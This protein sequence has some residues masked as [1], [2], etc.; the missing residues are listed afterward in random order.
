MELDDFKEAWQREKA[1]HARKI[2]TKAILAETKR[3]VKEK[4]RKFA[5]QQMI[6]ISCGIVFLGYMAG[7]YRRE[8][9]LLANA[10][11]TL[12]ILCL[13]LMLARSVILRFR[14]R[15]S[16]PWLPQAEFLE[17]ERKKIVA[18]IELLRRNVTWLLFPCLLGFLT[19]QIALSHS[20]G[21]AVALVVIAAIAA[22]V[23][24]W[25][26]RWKMKKELAPMLDD[27]DRDLEELRDNLESW[28][29]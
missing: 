5:R 24:I 27:I 9:P 1:A 28:P 29:D 15:E 18:R 25:F 23:A 19:W 11:L 3:K 7:W 22:V 6:Q 12:M 17:E 16:H 8:G 20:L 2:D 10:G 21:M 13:A 26:Y 14:L 4:D